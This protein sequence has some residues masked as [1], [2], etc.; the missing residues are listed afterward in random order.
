MLNG[1]HKVNRKIGAQRLFY[2][3]SND[4]ESNAETEKLVGQGPTGLFYK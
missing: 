1:S 3:F 2:Y 4:I